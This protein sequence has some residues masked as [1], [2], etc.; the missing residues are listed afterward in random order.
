MDALLLRFLTQVFFFQ[1]FVN[2]ESLL[3][4]SLRQIDTLKQLNL[5]R[6]NLI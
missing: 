3:S 4:I 5:L 6:S 2:E 1:D